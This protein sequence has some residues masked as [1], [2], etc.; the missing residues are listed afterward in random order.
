MISTTTTNSKVDS[1]MDNNRFNINNDNISRGV[2]LAWT[3]QQQAMDICEMRELNNSAEDMKLL[4]CTD[5][6]TGVQT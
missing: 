5:Y 6:V 2:G 3:L 1:N 4:S